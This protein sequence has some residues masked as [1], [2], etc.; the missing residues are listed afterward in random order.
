[1][2]KVSV[3]YPHSG[4]ASFDMKYYLEK[5]MPMVGQKLG[6][7]LLGNRGRPVHAAGSLAVDRWNG[8]ER[9]Q[10]RLIDIAPAVG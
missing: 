5:H 9:V 8:E 3:M 2:I 1:M 6:A 4:S 10:M 7:A